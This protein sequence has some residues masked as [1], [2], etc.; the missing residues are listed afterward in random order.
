MAGITI[1]EFDALTACPPSAPN[2]SGLR[3]VPK[4]VFDWLEAQALAGGTAWL[5]LMQKGGR[6][7]VQALGGYAGVIRAPDGY[8]I[9]V[10]PKIGRTTSGGQADAR[11]RQLFIRMLCCLARFRHIQTESAC[12]K[13]ARMP[14][15]EVFIGEFLRAAERVVKRGLRGDYVARRGNVFALRG[16]LQMAAHLRRNL[17]QSDRFFSL[18]RKSVV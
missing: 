14:L 2:A 15:L 10:L 18:D 4:P 1:Y 12:L 17:C 9:E 7:A 11:A 3:A 6:R 5:R 13:A 8:Q 16:K